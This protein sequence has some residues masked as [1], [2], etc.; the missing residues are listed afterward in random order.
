MSLIG[1]FS[2]FY[3]YIS[4]SLYAY[5]HL[6]RC[7]TWGYP[8]ESAYY[9]DASSSDAIL[10]IKIPFLAIS[11]I[12]DPVRIILVKYNRLFSWQVFRLRSKKQSHSRNSAKTPTQFSP[13]HPSVATYAGS[14]LVEL[15][16]TLARYVFSGWI[17]CSK[18]LTWMR[19]CA[20]FS[21]IWLSKLTLTI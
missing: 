17:G 10:S 6:P 20:I 19:R 12:D 2:K 15:A 13:Q 3:T 1:K 9:R 11:A 21:T 4:A 18:P 16:G 8:T 7:P 14:K 5:W